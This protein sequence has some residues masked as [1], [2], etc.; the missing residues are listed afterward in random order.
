[1]DQTLSALG[2]ILLKALPTFFLMLLLFGY[3]QKLFFRWG[4]FLGGSHFNTYR[5]V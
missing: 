2:G 4:M 3:L 5:S 1:M